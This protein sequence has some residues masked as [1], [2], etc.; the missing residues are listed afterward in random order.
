MVIIYIY[1]YVHKYIHLILWPNANLCLVVPISHGIPS[2]HR[3]SSSCPCL[4]PAYMALNQSQDVQKTIPSWGWHQNY[5]TWFSAHGMTPKHVEK[6]RTKTI[7]QWFLH[8]F[9]VLDSWLVVDLPLWKIWKS[10]GMMIPNI[11]KNKTYTKPPTRYSSFGATLSKRSELLHR[12]HGRK[13][14]AISMGHLRH[15][16][17]H[18]WKPRHRPKG[19]GWLSMSIW[20]YVETYSDSISCG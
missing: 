18:A 10:V 9:P 2:W 15:Q 13:I 7:L 5:R 3:I 12:H 20:I 11:W 17:T 14:P 1:I 4:T 8:V 6:C 16:V 19:R